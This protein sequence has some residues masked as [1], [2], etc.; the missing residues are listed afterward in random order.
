M[1]NTTI[2]MNTTNSPTPPGESLPKFRGCFPCPN[3]F[4]PGCKTEEWSNDSLVG[5]YV[6]PL[7]SSNGKRCPWVDVQEQHHGE[8]S[9]TIS[10]FLFFVC[11]FTILANILLFYIILSQK[12]LRVQVILTLRKLIS[13]HLAEKPSVPDFN[14][15]R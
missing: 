11:L 7:P 14:R 5:D 9:D 4:Y 10:S 15:V 2:A 8:K 3:P 6:C 12:E 1:S 13:N